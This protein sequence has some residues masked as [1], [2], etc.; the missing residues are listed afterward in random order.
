MRLG[1]I[2][3]CETARGIAIQ[4][5]GFYDAMP[6]DKVLLVRFP[7]P[8][9][10]EAPEWYDASRTTQVA[11][12]AKNHTL[13]ESVVREW[14]RG[15]DVVF[16]V[17]T[18]NDWRMPTWC[19]EEGVKLVVQGNP[20]FVRHGRPGFESLPHPDAWWWPTSWRLDHLPKGTVMPVPM[21]FE[22]AQRRNL[23]R[24][25]RV[26]HVVGKRAFADRNGTDQFVSAI[27]R[28][29]TPIHVT[30]YGLDGQLPQ[31]PHI[32]GNRRVAVDYF[33]DGVDDR[34]EMY[35]DQDVLV[36]P[37]RYGGLCL[38]ALEASA[39]GLAVVMPDCS[40]NSELAASRVPIRR[41][42]KMQ[43]AAGVIEGAEVNPADI[44]A[45]L[46][47]FALDRE[48]LHRTQREQE[49]LTPFWSEWFPRYL[50]E[51]HKVVGC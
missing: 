26:L 41:L 32:P 48:F 7:R 42:V 46:D 40:P 20:E 9:C 13:D 43:L 37:R 2:A 24:P 15:L 5:K 30:M 47:R 1:L 3:R 14:L 8:D 4:S 44:A 31:I 49:L 19:R 51:L 11:Y 33:P 27:R 10:R 25:L 28:V 12:D 16:T 22:W 50:T 17:E 21:S 35:R 18:P 34:W 39:C 29:R 36:L 38:P 6:V 23:D 45:T